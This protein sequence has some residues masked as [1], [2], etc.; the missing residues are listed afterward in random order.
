[1]SGES[2]FSS[3]KDAIAA[4]APALPPPNISMNSAEVT[5]SD[6]PASNKA[7]GASIV[8]GLPSATCPGSNEASTSKL[9][10]GAMSSP[11]PAFRLTR[12]LPWA[13]ILALSIP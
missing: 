1:M 5:S 4:N 13:N 8:M 9:G 12:P 10:A 7:M 6:L 3:P 11:V 2:T